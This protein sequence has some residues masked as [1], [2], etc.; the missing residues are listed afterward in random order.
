[1]GEQIVSFPGIIIESISD[2]VAVLDAHVTFHRTIIHGHLSQS[3]IGLL[4]MQEV[5]RY[6]TTLTLFPENMACANS[7]ERGIKL[8]KQSGTTPRPGIM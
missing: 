3:L 7:A 2:I 4:C 6:S 5:A 1:V 8:L